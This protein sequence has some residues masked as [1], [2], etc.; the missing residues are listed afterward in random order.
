MKPENFEF[1]RAFLKEKSGIIVTTDKTYLLE[2][3]LN[4]VAKANAFESIDHMAESLKPSPQQDVL[5]A[6]IEA[7]TT[8]ETSFFRDQRPFDTFSDVS[9]PYML[10]ARPA[11]KLKI[12]C[13][14][15]SS[16]QE[17]YSLS[18]L[19]KERADMNGW[20]V[21]ILGTDLSQDIIATAQKGL[22]SQFE[23]QR[24]LPIQLLVKYFEQIEEK[25]QLKDEIIKSVR[26]QAHNLL[27][28]FISFGVNDMIFCRNVLIYFDEET[29]AGI[30]KRIAAQLAPD[31]FL[32]L[33]G[34]ETV[35]GITDAFVPLPNVRGI[36]V[37][38][39]SIHLSEDSEIRKAALAS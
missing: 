11:R 8:N 28:S 38:P 21:D 17:P 1:Y 34:A 7:M 25:W 29:K 35:I 26:Y 23:V 33:G 19:M 4:P 36:Y 31:G 9:L 13:A 22:Y 32:V 10:S 2:S 6:I 30:L 24:G 27:D 12:W 20:N 15:S 3:R 39:N 18:M 14:A 37:H 16:G 5:M